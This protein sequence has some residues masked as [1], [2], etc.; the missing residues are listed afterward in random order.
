M[1]DTLD[2]LRKAALAGLGVSYPPTDMV[3]AHIEAGRPTGVL[4]DW[5]PPPPGYHL[6][7]PSRR[8]PNAAF[9]LVVNTLRHRS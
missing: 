9:A 7:Y 5:C 3:Q 6:C 4:A 8:R 1:F 2:L